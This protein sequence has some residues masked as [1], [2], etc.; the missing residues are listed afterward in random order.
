MVVLGTPAEEGGGGKI[1]LIKAGA[2]EDIDVAMMVHPSPDDHLYPPFIGIK[3][4]SIK[5]SMITIM[6]IIKL[7]MITVMSIIKLNMIAILKFY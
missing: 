1:M 6:S 5:L 7:S 2:F 4:V 3:R